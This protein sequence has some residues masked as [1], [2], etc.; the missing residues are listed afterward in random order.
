LLA[1]TVTTLDVVSGGRAELGIGA[2]WYEREHRGLG[3]PFP[4]LTE[5]FERLEA[6]L[7]IC[8]QMWSDENGPYDGRHYR[9]AETLCSPLPVSQPR[10]RILLGGGGEKKTLRLVAE[11]ADA[12]NI[13][14]GPDVVAQKVDVLRRHCDDVGRDPNEIEVTAMYRDLPPG[15]T[16]GQVI[17]GAQRLADVGVSTLVTGPVGHDPGGW[18]ES[19]FGP[20]MAELADIEPA[21]L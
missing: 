16:V 6:T 7:Q 5:R 2:A 14:G 9:L 21:R 4:P 19:T 12:C 1:K 10:P 20:A 15:A 8:L 11:Y 3:V 17:D 13:I 18:L